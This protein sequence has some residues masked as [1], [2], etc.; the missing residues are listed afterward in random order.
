[1]RYNVISHAFL[2]KF[3][4]YLFQFS[5][6]SSDEGSAF[7][8]LYTKFSLYRLLRPSFS[9]PRLISP[10]FVPSAFPRLPA[11]PKN[12]TD[13]P[14]HFPGLRQPRPRFQPTHLILDDIRNKDVCQFGDVYDRLG[15]TK[16]SVT[17]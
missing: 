1:M 7:G 15:S 6:I 3:K 10:R 8:K 4:F 12:I 9:A 13:R 5:P 14:E 17:N 2:F 11:F 16:V